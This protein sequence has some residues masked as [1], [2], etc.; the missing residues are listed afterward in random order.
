MKKTLLTML[1]AVLLAY[2]SEATL[3]YV[4]QTL[5]YGVGSGGLAIPDGSPVGVVS[6]MN[7]EANNTG[8]QM[9][10][11]TVGLDIS[12]GYNGNLYAYLISPRGTLVVLMD[13]PGSAPFY[14]PGQGM[15]VT[16]DSSAG[17]G[18]QE[19]SETYRQVLSGTYAPA[20]NLGNIAAPGGNDGT[21]N[22]TWT[23]LFADLTRGG[24]QAYLDSWT[25]NI[26]VVPEPVPLALGLF[27]VMLLA[28]AGIK[29][30][31]SPKISLD[32]KQR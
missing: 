14:A 3:S 20:G 5:T 31:W 15:D 18:I 19:A 16:L 29:R 22:G 12:G 17:T 9:I 26:T 13:Q 2:G 27:A 10:D 30:M 8:N 11:V 4:N 28:L 32:L 1:T 7:F 6:Q 21:G 25:L 24:G 23:L